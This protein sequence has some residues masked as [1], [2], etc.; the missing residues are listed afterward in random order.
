MRA[1]HFLMLAAAVLVSA[2][3]SSGFSDNASGSGQLGAGDAGIVGRTDG[4]VTDYG[5][6]LGGNREGYSA[7]QV[8]FDKQV[9][10]RV[11]FAFDSSELTS[12][13]RAALDRQVAYLKQ[14]PSLSATVEGHADERGTR[15]YNLALGER[16]ASAVK[17]YL[18]SGGVQARRLHTISYGKER[19]MELGSN[20]SAWARNRRAVTVID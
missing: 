18:V 2:C 6:D 20:E 17:N 14:F 11:F 3:T 16:R 9:G 8:Q 4:S 5:T 12:E 7:K 15:E 13:S 10:A 1:R 19:Q